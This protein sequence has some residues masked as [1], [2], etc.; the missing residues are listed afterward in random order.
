MD[1]AHLNDYAVG[2]CKPGDLT[3]RD[4]ATCVTIIKSGGAVDPEAAER[5]LPLVGAI[6][7]VRRDGQIVAVGAIKRIRREYAAK[8]AEKSRKQFP[9]DTPELG[10]VA[11]HPDH[12]G[13][14]LSSRIADAL[15]SQHAGPLFATTSSQRMKST[16]GKA[17]FSQEGQ[18]WEGGSGRLSLW[19]KG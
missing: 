7:I 12:Q 19:L 16:L 5:E 17:G 3:K 8:I 4:F 15:L 9:P 14:G 13:H 18:E 11:V 6:A 10:Y 2:A 1:Q